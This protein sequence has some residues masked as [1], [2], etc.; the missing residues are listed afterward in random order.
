MNAVIEQT[1][2][3]GSEHA[4]LISIFAA[5]AF[6]VLGILAIPQGA[7]S[8]GRRLGLS[9]DKPK[10]GPSLSYA[11]KGAR[12][13]LRRLERSLAPQ[14]G[15]KRSA[16]RRRLV[17][18]G[19]YGPFAVT[20]YYT[21]RVALAVVLPAVVLVVLPLTVGA[22]KIQTMYVL[23]MAALAAG[24][25]GPALLL[26]Q[27]IAGRQK[28]IREA[29]PDTLDTILVCVE[30]GLGLDAALVRVANEIE[31]ACPLM[32]EHFRLVSLEMQAGARREAALRNLAERV[33]VDEVSALVTLLVQS[34]AMGVSVANTLRVYAFEMRRK[35]LLR[36]EEH[37]NKLPVRMALPLAGFV[38]PAFLIIIS[39]PAVIRIVRAM[40][41]ALHR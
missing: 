32:C 27:R 6:F 38:M 9:V 14:D 21:L 33:G 41:P 18:A 30:A 22:L 10:I 23:T 36:A 24:Y 5:V 1:N 28:I 17:Q 37:A 3:L 4:I 40:L 2:F 13:L 35:R 29:F 15:G 39:T 34:D 11:D 7:P 25:F 20:I 19:Y 12:S 26:S 16:I 8:T 31:E